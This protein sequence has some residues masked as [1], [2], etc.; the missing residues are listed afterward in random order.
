MGQTLK[1][2]SSNYIVPTRPASHTV[3]SGQSL[4]V[5]AN[6]Y[7]ITTQQLKQFNN[8][9]SNSLKVGQKLK[10]PSTNFVRKKHKVRSGE[11]LSVIAKRYGTTTSAIISTN[12]LRSKSLAIGQVLTI[13]VS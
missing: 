4:S 8:L 10:I 9:R 11:S 3:S 6:K 5:I 2:P 12:K 1:I 7:D 13:P